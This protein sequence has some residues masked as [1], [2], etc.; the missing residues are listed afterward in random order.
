MRGRKGQPLPKVTP[1]QLPLQQRRWKAR[2]VRD[3]LLDC[4][5]CSW[6]DPFL[7][8]SA[9]ISEEGWTSVTGVREERGRSQIRISKGPKEHI[10]CCMLGAF[11]RVSTSEFWKSPVRPVGTPK[12]QMLNPHLSPLC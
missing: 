10:S 9:Q 11:S 12:S 2:V 8:S 3:G 6:R 5:A 1:Q 7:S 4:N